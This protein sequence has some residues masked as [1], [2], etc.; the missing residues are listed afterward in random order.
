MDYARRCFATA[1]VL[2]LAA[3]ASTDPNV[4]GGTT[5]AADAPQ[6]RVGDRWVYRVQEGFRNP[7]VFEET[8]TVT[9]VNGGAAT[10]R[11]SGRGPTLEFDR[12]EQWSAP[13]VV[14]QGTLFDIETRRFG[15]PLERYKFPLRGG[16]TWNQRLPNHND[17]TGRDGI[18]SRR[19]R[20][21]G[22]DRVTT[23]AG[24]FDAVR[25]DIIMRM[26]DEE[27][28][29]WPT[30][31]TYSV[32]YAPAAK[33]AVRE[34]KRAGYVEKGGPDVGALPAQNTT[35]ELLAYTPGAA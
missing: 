34:V 17:L 26:D 30:D 21:G 1:L 23:P 27:F 3:C 19:V 10:V 25:L 31:C 16:E 2:A 15:T 6:Y 5:V 18:V 11:V 14:A 32:W 29:R 28:W 33:N 4:T 8:H 12:V 22:Y 13:G 9:A 7:V 20:V 24:T 35:I